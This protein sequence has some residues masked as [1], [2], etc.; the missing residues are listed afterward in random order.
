M[1]TLTVQRWALGFQGNC[2][3][4]QLS[5]SPDTRYFQREL[6]LTGTGKKDSL[7]RF[8]F[9]LRDYGPL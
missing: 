7:Q 8:F 6:S 3:C 4:C 9:Y 2:W 1:Y 5:V